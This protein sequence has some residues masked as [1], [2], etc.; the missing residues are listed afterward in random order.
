MGVVA[1]TGIFN[2]GTGGADF[3]IISGLD[4]LYLISLPLPRTTGGRQKRDHSTLPTEYEILSGRTSFLSNECILVIGCS[5]GTVCPN[6][7]RTLE[8]SIPAVAVTHFAFPGAVG[9]LVSA[10]PIL[11]RSLPEDRLY[12]ASAGQMPV[13]S[14]DWRASRLMK[15]ILWPMV[16]P[17]FSCHS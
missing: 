17:R 13:D 15:P 2:G 8:T 10:R 4:L 7:S 9:T 11:A 14:P 6:P 16:V 3:F 12:V 1:D 5:P